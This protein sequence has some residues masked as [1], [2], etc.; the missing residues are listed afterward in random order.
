MDGADQRPLCAD[1]G[2]APEQELAEASRLLDL[3][4]Y[5]RVYVKMGHIS[6]NSSQGYPWRDTHDFVKRVCESYG[7]QRV[8]WG[9]DWPLCLDRLAYSQAIS[10]VCDEMAFFSKEDLEWIFH[11]AAMRCW[12]FPDDA[13]SNQFDKNGDSPPTTS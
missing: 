12:P 1:L 8:M 9:T 10:V 3:A 4:K 2:E 7:V 13:V 11:R 6:V 5:P